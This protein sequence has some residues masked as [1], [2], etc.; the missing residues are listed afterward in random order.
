MSLTAALA[1]LPSV[2]VVAFVPGIG[3]VEPHQP[4][5]TAPL[6]EFAELS[7]P[8]PDYLDSA[9]IQSVPHLRTGRSLV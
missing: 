2:L 8:S 1:V 5:M 7:A 9:P 6:S 4:A 3:D